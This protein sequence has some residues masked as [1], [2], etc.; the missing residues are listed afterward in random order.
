MD[1]YDNLIRINS[2]DTIVDHLNLYR[3]RMAPPH[4]CLKHKIGGPVKYIKD[5]ET[6]CLMDD[7]DRHIY[8]MVESE[9]S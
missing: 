1:T 3:V 4:C 8:K 2:D 7:Q 9:Y 5:K 6:I